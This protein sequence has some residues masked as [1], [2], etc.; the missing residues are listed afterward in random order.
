MMLRMI[1]SIT[2]LFLIQPPF[3]ISFFFLLPFLLILSIKFFLS[4]LFRH[5]KWSQIAQEILIEQLIQAM[6]ME[7]SL[8]LIDEVRYAILNGF[9]YKIESVIT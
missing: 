7:W 1:H 8:P 5:N 4:L 6:I 2:T 9:R 3:F